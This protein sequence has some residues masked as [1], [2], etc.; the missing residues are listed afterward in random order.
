MSFPSLAVAPLLSPPCCSPLAVVRAANPRRGSSYSLANDSGPPRAEQTVW[1]GGCTSYYKLG[2]KV[3]ATFPGT[4][5]EFWWRT[6]EPVWEDYHQVG[7]TTRVAARKQV[8]KAAK[9]LAL[10]AFVLACRRVGWRRIKSEL[11]IWLLVSCRRLYRA[12]P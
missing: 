10:L 7:G 3:I 1:N 12:A 5:T 4:T 9:A 2:D 8:V 11:I 6:R